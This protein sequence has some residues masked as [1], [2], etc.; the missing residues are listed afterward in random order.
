[1][2]MFPLRELKRDELACD[3]LW[4]WWLQGPAESGG[5]MAQSDSDVERRMWVRGTLARIKTH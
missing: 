4:S 3:C 5:I 1:M 2:F